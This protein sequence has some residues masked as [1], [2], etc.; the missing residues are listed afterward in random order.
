MIYVTTLFNEF[1]FCPD[2]DLVVFLR[3]D[4]RTFL[5]VQGLGEPPAGLSSAG[6]HRFPIR[7]RHERRGNSAPRLAVSQQQFDTLNYSNL[8][9]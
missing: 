3:C 5:Y 2:V 4:P 6:V 1:A 9:I 8:N 7:S